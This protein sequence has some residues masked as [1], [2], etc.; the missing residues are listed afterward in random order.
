MQRPEGTLART[1]EDQPGCFVVRNGV[2]DQKKF[3]RLP[4]KLSQHSFRP[5]H[6]NI[7]LLLEDRR[8]RLNKS[9]IDAGR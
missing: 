4:L 6:F 2:A 7:V 1:V 3:V 8:A 9:I 5:N